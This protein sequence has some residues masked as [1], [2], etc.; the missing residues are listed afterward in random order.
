M[1]SPSLALPT[2][3][4]N[5]NI[6]QIAMEPQ[7]VNMHKVTRTCNK[8]LVIPMLFNAF[9]FYAFIVHSNCGYDE[10]IEKIVLDKHFFHF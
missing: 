3:F 4:N 10:S 6:N 9:I 5:N 8:M 7:Q 2:F 1:L